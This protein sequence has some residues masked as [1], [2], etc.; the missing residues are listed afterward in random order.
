M[1]TYDKNSQISNYSLNPSQT[2]IVPR[3][4]YRRASLTMAGNPVNTNTL[5][6]GYTGSTVTY[7]F[8]TVLGA[9]AAGNV[10]ILL[11][12][13]AKLACQKLNN[14]INGVTDAPNIAYGTGTKPH[15]DCRSGF[16]V[17]RFALGTTQIVANA[18]G[19]LYLRF[20]VG[21]RTATAFPS[22][23]TVGGGWATVNNFT[24]IFSQR[25][26]MNGNAATGTP[27]NDCVAGDFQVFQPMGWVQDDAGNYVYYSVDDVIVEASSM[28]VTIVIEADIYYSTDEVT[29]V[30]IVDG[31]NIS[32]NVTTGAGCQQFMSRGLRIPPGAGLY[33]KVRSTDT[34]SASTVD[35][36]VQFHRYPVGV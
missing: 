7:T 31:L 15:P 17:I 30:K 8:V 23:L 28:A 25:Y 11:Q 5:V 3:G 16:T 2:A 29:F 9:P 19:S 34:S 22:T 13:T 33:I 1:A 21:D 4:T 27:P 20:K 35:L 18:N 26:V 14:A 32:F 6:I 12:S 10:E 36:K 24:R